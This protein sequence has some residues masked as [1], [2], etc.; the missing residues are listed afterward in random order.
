MRPGIHQPKLYYYPG[1]PVSSPAKHP[2]L[3]PPRGA[4][5]ARTAVI[6]VD[7][8]THELT[9]VNISLATRAWQRPVVVTKLTNLV[10][11]SALLL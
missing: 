6:I 11:M 9:T 2:P 5:T 7:S 10:E 3:H 4:G 1:Y 8:C